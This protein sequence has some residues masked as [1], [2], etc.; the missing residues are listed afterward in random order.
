MPR[1]VG[2]CGTLTEARAVARQ[3]PKHVKTLVVVSSAPHMRR[4]LLAF[5]RSVPAHVRVVPYAATTYVNSYELYHP[6][7]LEYVKLLVYYV[8]A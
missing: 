6:I 8:I 2:L 5:R 4:T 3:L 1:S 7:W